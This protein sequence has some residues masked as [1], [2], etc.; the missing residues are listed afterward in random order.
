MGLGDFFNKAWNWVADKAKKVV[1]T[2]KDAANTVW[3]K[4]KDLGKKVAEVTKDV[5]KKAVEIIKKGA[6]GTVE[7]VKTVYTD[8]IKNPLEAFEA[9]YKNVTKGLSS[10]L[11]WIALAIGAVVIVPPLLSARAGK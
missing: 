3:Q 6:E 11:T 5:G 1:T 10:P 8:V 4:T 7:A 2:V 9:G